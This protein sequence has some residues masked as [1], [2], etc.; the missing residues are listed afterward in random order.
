MSPFASGD[1]SPTLRGPMSLRPALRHRRPR[2]RIA[3][4]GVVLL[5]LAG[6]VVSGCVLDWEVPEGEDTT[7]ATTGGTAATGGGVTSC[8][9]DC[10]CSAGATCNFECGLDACRIIAEAGSVVDVDCGE[11]CFE[12]KKDSNGAGDEGWSR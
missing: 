4:R 9:G 5:V 10:V 2:A 1:R 8:S 12:F 11:D 6:S 3:R 7:S